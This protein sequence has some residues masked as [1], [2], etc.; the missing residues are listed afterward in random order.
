MQAITPNTLSF[1][2]DLE[3][4]N[5]RDWYHEHKTEYQ[6]ARQDF[7]A[8]LRTLIS[9]ITEA[10]LLDLS[11]LEPKDAMYRIFRDL[12]FHKDKPPYNPWFS[13]M[14]GPQGR[15]T[16][17]AAFYIRLQPG[18]SYVGAGCSSYWKGDM[19]AALRQEIDYHPEPLLQWMA[20]APFQ[21]YFGE[22]KGEALKRPPKGYAADHPQVRWLK[23]KDWWVEHTLPDELL[24]DEALIP[25]LLEVYAAAQP[26]LAY[27]TTS[28]EDIV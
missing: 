14:L 8:W 28:I 20:G 1:L 19:L 27:L 5:Q 26:L 17:V 3:A 4:N 6:Q 13:A 15:N 18:R 22:I 21:K 2:K 25:Y 7:M 16:Q 10:N 24:H 12:R 9:G 23:Q 11:G